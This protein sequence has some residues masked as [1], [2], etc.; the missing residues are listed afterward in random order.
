MNEESNVRMNKL[1]GQRKSKKQEEA[2]QI[3]DAG[4]EPEVEVE[5][6]PEEEQPKKKAGRPKKVVQETYDV[7]QQEPDVV[8]HKRHKGAKPR[9][10]IVVTADSEADTSDEEMPYRA[11]PKIEIKKRAPKVAPAPEPEPEPQPQPPRRPKKEVTHLVGGN[12]KTEPKDAGKGLPQ[13]HVLQ[14]PPAPKKYVVDS[15]IDSLLGLV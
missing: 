15:F 2:R 5:E 13:A 9:K 14:N 3:I 12:P 6:Q 8:I 4:E 1:K 7:E 11:K 10:I